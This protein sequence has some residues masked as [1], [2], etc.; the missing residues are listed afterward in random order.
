MS[1]TFA[2]IRVQ[3]PSSVPKQIPFMED[4]SHQ[5]DRQLMQRVAAR[6][7]DALKT[8]YEQYS[9]P[10]Y[11]MAY[12]VT[13]QQQAAEDV[14]QD[15]FFQIW[16]W[17]ERWNP[18]KGRFISWVLTVTRYT[19][20]DHVRREQRQ[21]TLEPPS[22]EVMQPSV[23]GQHD[24]YAEADRNREIRR[25]LKALPQEQRTVIMLAFFRGMTHD[26]IAKH[27]KLPVGTVKSRIRLGMKKLREAM[28][29]S[30]SSLP[31]SD[32]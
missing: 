24:A 4:A 5:N 25:H 10:I 23:N 21:P 7:Q 20:I 13:R 9:G 6:E 15:V 12:Q 17:P 14:T 30:S 1:L 8:L 19:A 27:L 16:R 31:L 32:S 11:N 3:Q 26:E 18:D 22:D 2:K 29:P 28:L